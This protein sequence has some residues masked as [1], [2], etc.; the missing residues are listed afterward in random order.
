ML[1]TAFIEHLL[2]LGTETQTRVYRLEF[3]LQIRKLKLRV[4]LRDT[5]KIT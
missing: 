5:A 2:T 1:F 4:V 3:T